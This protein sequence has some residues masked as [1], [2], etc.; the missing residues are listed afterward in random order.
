MPASLL[1]R[2]LKSNSPLKKKASRL[3]HCSSHVRSAEYLEDRRVLSVNVNSI[4]PE[5]QIDLNE[6]VLPATFDLGAEV[7]GVIYFSGLAF[8]R[9]GDDAILWSYDPAAN[10]GTGEVRPLE[11]TGDTRDLDFVRQIDGYDGKLYVRGYDAFNYY[12]FSIDLATSVVTK[13]ATFHSSIN[14]D[15]IT[16]DDMI[17]HDGSL[18]YRDDDADGNLD[19]WRYTPGEGTTKVA[20]FQM[21]NGEAAHEMLLIND[22][23]YLSTIGFNG[24]LQIWEYDPAVEGV[25]ATRF[26]F[27]TSVGTNDS[28]EMVAASGKIYFT[29]QDN[30][31][32][33][34]VDLEAEPTPTGVERFYLSNSDIFDLV[35]LKGKLYW[36]SSQR[37]LVSFW[38]FDPKSSEDPQNLGY[39]ILPGQFPSIIN[40]SAGAD[41]LY[42]FTSL[43]NHYSA[44]GV[45][46][47]FPGEAILKYDPSQQPADAVTFITDIDMGT[48]NW[49]TEK[50]EVF[51]V[52]TTILFPGKVDDLRYDTLW[53]FDEGEPNELTEVRRSID[54]NESSNPHELTV[55]GDTLFFTAS[56]GVHGYEVWK[57]TIQEDGRLA[58]PEMIADIYTGIQGSSPQNLAVIDGVL[59]FDAA[60]QG[61]DFL[62]QYEPESGVLTRLDRVG[63]HT[64]VVTVGNRRYYLWFGS[65]ELYLDYYDVRLP[66]EVGGMTEVPDFL[67]ERIK[68]QPHHTTAIGEQIYFAIENALTGSEAIY[69]YD[70]SVNNGTEHPKRVELPEGISSPKNFTGFNGKVYF[71]ALNGTSKGELFEY[72]PSEDLIRQVSDFNATSSYSFPS[73]LTVFNDQLYF[74]AKDNS[75]TFQLWSFDPAANGGLGQ[76]QLA[77][78]LEDR[79]WISGSYEN[80]ASPFLVHDGRMYL[81]GV[82]SI[83][84]GFDIMVVEPSADGRLLTFAESIQNSPSSYFDYEYVI[85]GSHVF[86]NMFDETR[87]RELYS[88]PLIS[89]ELNAEFRYAADPDDVAGTVENTPSNSTPTFGE[90]DLLVGQIW[91]TVGPNTAE[92]LFDLTVD[93]SWDTLW[94]LGPEVTSHLG[95]EATVIHQSDGGT[96]TASVTISDID[97][98]AF[99]AG[100]RVLVGTLEFP[101][102]PDNAANLPA[103]TVGAYPQP[104]PRQGATLIS[105]HNN[106]TQ[107][108]VLFD[109]EQEDLQL[110]AMQ[111]DANEDD[112]IG[113]A[114][115]AQFIRYYGK[116]ADESNPQA[117]RFDYNR[118][119][120]VGLADFALFISRYGNQKFPPMT[121]AARQSTELENGPTAQTSSSPSGFPLEGEPEPSIYLGTTLYQSNEFVFDDWIGT[122]S[123]DE[124]PIAAAVDLPINPS[125]DARLVDAAM[126]S[127][128]MSYSAPSEE[129]AELDLTLSTEFD[130]EDSN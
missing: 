81:D 77:F 17:F 16:N 102:D 88:L 83:S 60:E 21:G 113:I 68:G 41:Y 76:V 78:E 29:V 15:R 6:Q 111:Y 98:S 92:Q 12:L 5:L 121:Q 99:Q 73:R 51:E 61:L 19:L 106:T 47:T 120:R 39:D 101:L 130:S 90:W 22:R 119:G 66:A 80:E 107:Q 69:I 118:D 64:D 109:D 46:Y 24:K 3:G 124:L 62:W 45:N 52:G 116:I 123:Q 35:A 7:D 110:T 49:Y 57:A 48:G 30:R 115:F 103:D 122:Q 87:G 70:T 36:T 79:S 95:S 4:T 11:L 34:E 117:Y 13:I 38:E 20:D 8:E 18:Y 85:A 105:V 27:E 33:W 50:T 44:G 58:N 65:H 91:L 28:P 108:P 96:R 25:E 43:S 89:G 59:Y 128:A 63:P 126:Q 127:E 54:L 55:I 94:F 86:T 40:L 67:I 31:S 9:R 93:L 112:R 125:W 82:R 23:I 75:S 72:D 129:I 10:E 37:G 14:S 100:D 114:D 2:F 84:R 53:R 56:D 97:L 42:L 74:R 104:V 1:S 71:Q 32:L 26:V